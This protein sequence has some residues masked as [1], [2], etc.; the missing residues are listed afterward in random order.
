MK[1]NSN[2][3]IDIFENKQ[4]TFQAIFQTSNEG[5]IVVNATGQVQLINP[6]AE[7]MF[8]YENN[9]LKGKNIDILVP[10]TIRG[11]H[12]N[13]R[14]R[15]IKN[16]DPRPMGLGRDLEGQRKDGSCFPL[17]VSLSNTYIENKQFVVA[18]IIDI[19]RRKKAEEALKRSE[20]Q[21]ITYAS[22]LEQRVK[23]RTDDLKASIDT[24]ES[25]NK[26]LKK[27][28]KDTRMALSKERELNELK[29]R[30]VSMASHEFRTP[31]SSIL[32]SVS[33]ID[34]YISANNPEKT[35]KHI[36]RIKSSVKSVGVPLSSMTAV[37][38]E[39]AVLTLIR[40]MF[41]R[42]EAPGMSLA[43]TMIALF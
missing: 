1:V 33:L 3:P 25:T 19:S 11:N 28:E 26:K 36:D 17:E 7:K 4:S 29:S 13:L 39:P 12:Q 23:K 15:Y 24:L 35:V 14:D 41:A 34:K 32:S 27:A 10:D 18:F 38:E 37:P 40:H 21:L 16:P 22:E 8:G 31:L 6:T 2:N 5:I 20:E 9:E 43:S 42:P 30:F